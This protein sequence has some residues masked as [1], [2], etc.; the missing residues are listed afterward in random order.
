MGAGI[1]RKC[2][3]GGERCEYMTN[4]VPAQREQVKQRTHTRTTQRTGRREKEGGIEKGQGI[5][6]EKCMERIVVL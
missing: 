2:R 6:Q 3:G 4:I 1:L 5:E